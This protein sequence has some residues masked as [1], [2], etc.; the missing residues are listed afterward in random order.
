[1]KDRKERKDRERRGGEIAEERGMPIIVAC[2]SRSKA[3]SAEMVPRKGRH[4]FAIQRVSQMLKS[5]GY[6]K[7]ILKSDQG[8]DICDLKKAVR[9]ECPDIEVV[10]EES[11]VGEHQS[12]G[13]VE[14]AIRQAQGVFRSMKDALESRLG[15]RLDGECWAIPWLIRHATAMMNRMHVH[16]N[17]KTSYEYVKGKRYK[18]ETIEF[19]ERLHYLKPDSVGKDKFHTRW[20]NGIYCG[21]LDE[22][23][24]ILIGTSSGMVKVRTI[25]WF[26]SQEERWNADAFTQI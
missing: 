6:R 4:P 11:P 26:A 15:K 10:M 2:D 24:E 9:L 22:S 5:L 3:K 18:R 1:M 13:Q 8:N 20:N 14:N 17:G 16:P 25:K 19:G 12:N 21:H 23:G 7:V